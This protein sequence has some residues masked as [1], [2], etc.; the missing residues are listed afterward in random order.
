VSGIIDEFDK[1]LLV[2][3]FFAVFPSAVKEDGRAEDD[4]DKDG[5]VLTGRGTQVFACDEIQDADSRGEKSANDK[6][7][8]VKIFDLHA[9]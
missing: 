2:Y 3:L 6:E 7:P 4:L 1:D 5:I 8:V 9:G